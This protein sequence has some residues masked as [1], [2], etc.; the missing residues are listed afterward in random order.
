LTALL[1]ES[2]GRF[3]LEGKIV[4]ISRHWLN[5]TCPHGR[6]GLVFEAIVNADPPSSE[7]RRA[8][9][10]EVEFESIDT[11]IDATRNIGYPIRE[12]GPYGSHPMHDDFDDESDPDGSGTY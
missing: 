5:N 7:S 12:N 3:P 11:R 2:Q 10:G 8:K 4:L 1:E 9:S 6:S